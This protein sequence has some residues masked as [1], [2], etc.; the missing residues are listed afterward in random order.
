MKQTRRDFLK[1]S[2]APKRTLRS[3]LLEFVKNR[4]FQG[5]FWCGVL[6]GA[7]VGSLPISWSAYRDGTLISTKTFS[8]LPLHSTI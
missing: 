5:P 6:S 1:A 8:G 3:A 2:P 7:A 4:L